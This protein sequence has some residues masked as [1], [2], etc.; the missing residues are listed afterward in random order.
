MNRP[1]TEHEIKEALFQMDGQKA[2]G[3]DG[4]TALFFQ[5]FWGLVEKLIVDL[6]LSCFR[7][8]TIPTGLNESVICLILKTQ[9]L[10]NLNQFRPINLCNVI[11]KIIS[12]VIANRLKP[13]MVK[14]TSRQQVSF[15]PGRSTSDNIT[16]AHEV[17]HSLS[18][19]KGSNG[20][21]IL[22]VDLEKAYDR[23]E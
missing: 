12:K 17:I 4:Y 13:V 22:K 5:K 1:V 16:A 7:T 18:R 3:P 15:I 21:F 20:G 2:P 23:V 10:D 8:S 9:A 11:I 14:L 6:V 19:R